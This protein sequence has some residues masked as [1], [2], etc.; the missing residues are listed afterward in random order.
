MNDGGEIARR[1]RSG[2]TSPTAVV[3][4]ALAR[5]EGLEP[6]LRAWMH[7]DADGALQA[8][9]ILAKES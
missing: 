2:D 4:A 1:I 3:K 8:A 7:L 5:A 9:G 6:R